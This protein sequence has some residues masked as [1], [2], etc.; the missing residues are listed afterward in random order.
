LQAMANNTPR[1]WGGEIRVGILVFNDL[2]VKPTRPFHPG[3][4]DPPI[5]N[6]I[7]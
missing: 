1:M 6:R 5:R 4:T 2:R 3:Q 7:A